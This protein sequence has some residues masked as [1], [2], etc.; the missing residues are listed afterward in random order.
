MI[1]PYLG[2]IAIYSAT[3]LA[4][5][6]AL[7]YFLAWKGRENLTRWGRKFFYLT[8]GSIFTASFCLLYAILTH[9][10]QVGYV[11]NYSS[12]DLPLY[13]LI[14]TFWGGQEGTYLL[15]IFYTSILGLVLLKKSG[16]FEK[17]N[18][19]FISLFSISVLA[20]LIKRSPFTLL[21]TVP[22]EGVGLNPLLQ[23]YWMT[24]HPL[25][26]FVGFAATVIPFA[27]ALSALIARE[28]DSW[29]A[30]VFPWVIL[31]FI[32]LGAALVMGGFWAYET[33]GWGGYWGWDPVENSS[34]IPWLF[35]AGLIHTLIIHKKK[36][37]LK[38]TGFLLAILA[39][40]A[41]VY[42]TF[43]TRSGILGDFSVHSFLELGINAYLIGSV[44]IFG[45]LGG[46]ILLYR[47]KEIKG[48]TTSEDWLSREFLVFGNILG[49]ILSGFLVLLGMS[50]PLITRWFGTPASV[51]PAYYNISITPITIIV[52]FFL[53]L[54]P[55]LS[56]GN[57]NKE[58]FWKNLRIPLVLAFMVSSLII[59][60]AVRKPLFAIFIFMSAFAFFSN[61]K[62][63][64]E[65]F[66]NGKVAGAFLAHAGIA[67][68]FIGVIFSNVYESRARVYL[69]PGV[70]QNVLGYTFTYQGKDGA[71]PQGKTPHK[72]LVQR[73]S[74]SFVAAPRQFFTAYN[75]GIMHKPYIKRYWNKDVYIAP[76]EENV[77]PSIT[78]QAFALRKGEELEIKG[79]KFRFL[80]FQVSPHGQEANQE[81]GALLE[82]ITPEGTQ[83]ITPKLIADGRGF[84]QEPARFY[85]DRA[86]VYLEDVQAD[87]GSVNLRIVGQSANTAEI[88]QPG[89]AIE[90]S[91]KPFINLF[92]GGSILVVVGGI[93]SLRKRWQTASLQKKP[94]PAKS[95][96]KTEAVPEKISV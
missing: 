5:L 76:I 10:F 16:K 52:T 41:V 36:N 72:I 21:S 55:A 90:V 54:L 77:D 66:R 84:R 71:T 94:V 24:I 81:V 75:Q 19:F 40:L 63:V 47:S 58:N 73:G 4:I 89:F 26:M 43:L 49:F 18:F 6:T 33:L 91:L 62:I 45:L 8:T 17:G 2:K 78:E 12:T 13:Y 25:V 35:S 83:P 92:W 61:G 57:N 50:T 1:I 31:S 56:W 69:T 34:L 80:E 28:Y 44:I 87:Q 27:F 30:Y 86:L 23:N 42:G 60:T 64:W 20:I 85:H 93:F 15:W 3:F 59:V 11:Y 14:A 37:A 96:E 79:Y 88:P 82:V 68:L 51:Q 32:S 48:Q 67:L 38:R 53:G 70:P 65:K 9:D 74:H 29:V 39:Y 7:T 22:T 46:G 95:E